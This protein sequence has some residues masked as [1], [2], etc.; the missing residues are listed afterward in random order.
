[1][2][3][4]FAVLVLIYWHELG[5]VCFGERCYTV[6][7]ISEKSARISKFLINVNRVHFINNFIWCADTILVLEVLFVFIMF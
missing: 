5:V 4:Y 2:V 6:F 7:N 1:M 3:M